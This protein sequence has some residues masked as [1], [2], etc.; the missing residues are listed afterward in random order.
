M[1][2]PVAGFAFANKTVLVI[3]AVASLERALAVVAER[4]RVVRAW[5]YVDAEVAM[6]A[7][8]QV[9]AGGERLP[10]AGLVLGV[11]D[12]FDTADMPTEYGSAIYR[13]YRPGADAAAV[14]MLRSAGAVS[15]GKTVTAELALYTPG[16]TTNPHRSTHTPGGSSSGSAAAVAAGMADITLGTQTAGSVI[17]PASYCGVYGYKP[18]YGIVATSGVKLIAPSLD[19]VGWF[20]HSVVHLDAVRVVLTGRPSYQSLSRPP[21]LGVLRGEDW[22]AADPDSQAVVEQA[23]QIALS[24][25]AHLADIELP[26]TMKGLAGRVPVVQGYEAARSLSWE[27]LNHPALLSEPL[28]ELLE[29]GGGIEPG[30]HDKVLADARRARQTQPDLF[31]NLDAILTPAA[32]GEAPP[33]LDTTG[34]PR[35]NRLWTLLGLP[36]I[37][38]PGL[39][40]S[41]GMPLGVQLVSPALHDAQLLACAEW[42]GQQLRRV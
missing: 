13:G 11:K 30:E 36:A 32:A 25:G 23:V 5:S 22:E 16:A 12:I 7:A 20:T 34:D 42:L 15:L 9:D 26:P 6:A 18:T 17:R 3:G 35:F 24:A 14:A 39:T 29:W 33:T 28:R 4:E 27:R 31:D 2:V 1:T 41:T 38:V 40:G 37:N 8:R 19:T 21:R 10:L